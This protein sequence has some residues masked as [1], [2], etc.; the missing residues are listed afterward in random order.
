[1]QQQL[2][3]SQGHLTEQAFQGLMQG[4]LS[5]YERLKTAEH[6]AQCDR[7]VLH[8]TQLL[9]AD[10]GELMAPPVPQADGVFLRIKRRL[11]QSALSRYGKVTIAASLALVLWTVGAFQ[12]RTPLDQSKMTQGLQNVSQNISAHT[13]HWMEQFS[14]GFSNFWNNL[15]LKGVFQGEEKE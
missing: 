3:D 9:C 15:D 7:C 12:M 5:E 6:M 11:R 4:S 2:F 8:Y 13:N 1:M 10:E 14:N